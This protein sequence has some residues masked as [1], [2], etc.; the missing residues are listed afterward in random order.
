[1]AKL[2]V[3]VLGL[4]IFLRLVD[5]HDM[6]L[7]ITSIGLWITIIKVAMVRQPSLVDL[8]ALAAMLL[9][10]AHKRHLGHSVLQEKS[11][12]SADVK[13]DSSPGGHSDILG[14]PA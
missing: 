11:D 6:V 10:Y 5:S 4:M 13:G 8:T 7:S 14:V 9:S 1:M 12:D 2:R 3:F